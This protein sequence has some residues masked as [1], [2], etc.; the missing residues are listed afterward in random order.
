MKKI[1]TFLF[2]T[3]IGAL[4]LFGCSTVE[5]A[6]NGDT[7]RLNYTGKLEDGTVFDSSEGREPLEFVVGSGMMIP[8]LE[9]GII[10][11]AVTETKTIT[12]PMEEAYGP[13]RPDMIMKAPKDKLPPDMV[14]EVGQQLESRQPDG[15]L[16][17]AT[18]I[19]IT[20]D[21]VTL[22]T[23]HPLAGKT[24]TFEVEIIKITKDK[25]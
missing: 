3:S 24:L 25:S 10:G 16:M 20:E 22:D 4:L 18:V 7:V 14:Y 12:I 1:L 21:T 17:F 2:I 23:N 13:K 19:E 9:K 5:K 15:R 6:E 11:M 8:G